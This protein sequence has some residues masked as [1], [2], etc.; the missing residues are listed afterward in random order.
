MPGERDE[1]MTAAH[2]RMIVAAT[3]AA[4]YAN[5]QSNIIYSREMIYEEYAKFYQRIMK[6]DVNPV[7]VISP[8]GTLPTY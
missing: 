6:D 3:L 5:S 1:P 4:G 8:P 2:A 7:P